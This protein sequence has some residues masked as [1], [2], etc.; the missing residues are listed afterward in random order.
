M[1]S[2][3]RQPRRILFQKCYKGSPCNSKVVSQLSW[4]SIGLR[5]LELGRISSLQLGVAVRFLFHYI[6]R[7]VQLIIRIF[8][9]RPVT[10][11]SVGTRIGKGKGNV[12]FWCTYVKKGQILF[13]LYGATFSVGTTAFRIIKAKLPF[14]S[15]LVFRRL[16]LKLILVFGQVAEW[17][18]RLAVDQMVFYSHLVGSNPTFPIYFGHIALL[19][20]CVGLQNLFSFLDLN[21]SNPFVACLFSFIFFICFRC[22]FYKPLGDP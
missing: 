4:G 16:A 19:V 15:I 18:S 11:T 1:G 22:L 20:L 2:S 3:L 8:P 12:S 9:D 7:G 14:I 5:S 6:P 21:G 17:L 13:E 10:T